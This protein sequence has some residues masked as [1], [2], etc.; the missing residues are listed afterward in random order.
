MGRSY[1]AGTKTYISCYSCLYSTILADE[2]DNRMVSCGLSHKTAEVGT[3]KPYPKWCKLY[4]FNH[5]RE[6]Q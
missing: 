6:D 2:K 5:K 1:K 3:G 4:G